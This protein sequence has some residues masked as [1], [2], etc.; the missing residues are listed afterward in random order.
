MI[1]SLCSTSMFCIR[2]TLIGI[3]ITQQNDK[4]TQIFNFELISSCHI[5]VMWFPNQPTIKEK[6]LTPS[7]SW[8]TLLKMSTK[9]QD[10]L[11]PNHW[12]VA[13]NQWIQR[14]NLK[15]ASWGHQFKELF[16]WK[17]Y[18]NKTP[19][20]LIKHVYLKTFFIWLSRRPTLF[21]DLNCQSTYVLGMDPYDEL[22]YQ[23]AVLIPD[24]E[25]SEQGLTTLW[26]DQLLYMTLLNIFWW[27]MRKPNGYCPQ[28]TCLVS[29]PLVNPTFLC[30]Q[31]TIHK[32]N[33]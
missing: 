2:E 12:R 3:R 30:H 8:P 9:A 14:G 24:E 15:D 23:V 27:R 13:L 16:S 1:A 4:S 11:N 31:Y 26:P 20:Q 29:L 7:P 17:K 25:Q 33:K 10:V 28:H 5:S 6:I 18:S 19:N 32:V 22:L 21:P